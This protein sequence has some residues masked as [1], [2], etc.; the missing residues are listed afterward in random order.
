MVGGDAAAF[1]TCRPI[2]A[3]VG[4]TIT[5]VGGSGAGQVCK[6]C[7]QI[8]V[9]TNLAGVCEA[10]HFAT[11]NGLDVA[12]MIGVVGAGAGASWQLA[13]LGPKIVAGDFAPAF[14]IDLALKDLRIV[15]SSG[16][17]SGAALRAVVEARR[18][19]E[20][21]RDQ[22]GEALGTQAMIRALLPKIPDAN[23]EK[24]GKLTRFS[25]NILP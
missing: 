23:A 10:V 15:E 13:N 14:R 4:K 11:Q 25:Y 2:F 16:A 8:A 22:G 9:L 5:H 3:A 17:A 21:V 24:V 7:N 20:R 18:Y 1:E 12:K 19:L 6:A